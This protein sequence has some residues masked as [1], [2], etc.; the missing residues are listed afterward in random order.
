[1][2]GCGLFTTTEYKTEVKVIEVP[3]EMTRRLVYPEPPSREE[4]VSAERA[5]LVKMLVDLYSYSIEELS[6]GNT[7][8]SDIEAFERR[9]KAIYEGGE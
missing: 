3:G 7:Q 5:R 2:G 8:F 1:M 6:K 4:L 9:Q